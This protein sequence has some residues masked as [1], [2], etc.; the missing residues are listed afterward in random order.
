M[1]RV[2][3]A[4]ETTYVVAGLPSVAEDVEFSVS[5]RLKAEDVGPDDFALISTA[6]VSLLTATHRVD[7]EY[8]IVTSESG[9]IAMRTPVRPD[10]IEAASILLYDV[11]GT[12]ELL[13]RATIWPF[14]G[15]KATDWTKNVDGSSTISIVDGIAA[16]EPAEAGFSEDLVRAWYILTEQPVVT[17]L[18]AI[19]E[20]AAEERIVQTR[21]LLSRAA[22]D[23]YSNRRDVRKELLADTSVD[24]DRLVEFL[25]RLEYALDAECR[26]AAYSLIAR[27]AGATRYPLIREIP[28]WSPEQ[29]DAPR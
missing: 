2:D 26:T 17:H 10:E 27:G 1:L 6:E 5:D 9:A 15:I 18:L 25:A 28:W 23:G 24:N 21:S 22:E 7:P 29:P 4:L 16:L 3:R 8:G 14:Y 11:S 12:S 20:A 19:P 13:A